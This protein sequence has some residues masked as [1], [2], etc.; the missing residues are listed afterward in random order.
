MNAGS[1]DED[2]EDDEM[3]Q[4]EIEEED[5]GMYITA[6]GGQGLRFGRGAISFDQVRFLPSLFFFKNHLVWDGRLFFGW[7]A[8]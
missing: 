3:E 1:D 5:T 7:L 2:D 4:D 6:E 8:S